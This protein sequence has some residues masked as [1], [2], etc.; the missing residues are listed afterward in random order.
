MTDAAIVAFNRACLEGRTNQ[1]NNGR[2]TNR[3][4]CH[5]RQPWFTAFCTRRTWPPADAF[6]TYKEANLLDSRLFTSR[7]TC[8]T[9]KQVP[10]ISPAWLHATYRTT[11]SFSRNSTPTVPALQNL[12]HFFDRMTSARIVVSGELIISRGSI[13]LQACTRPLISNIACRAPSWIIS[14]PCSMTIDV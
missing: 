14:D 4:I 8:Q 9:P 10:W 5:C 7:C 11:M 1:G 3:M 2:P 13:R 12:S 6:N